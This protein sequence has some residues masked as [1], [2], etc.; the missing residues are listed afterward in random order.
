MDSMGGSR[1]HMEMGGGR[2]I[3]MDIG[4]HMGAPRLNP[5]EVG[6]GRVNITKVE[7]GV[8]PLGE[9]PLVSFM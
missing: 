5:H 2:A 6:G 7:E 9:D 4:A 8:D 1:N 3:H